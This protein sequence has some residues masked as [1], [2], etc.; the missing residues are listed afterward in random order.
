[1]IRVAWIELL[2]CMIIIAF[3]AAISLSVYKG[4]INNA[5]VAH[6]VCQALDS[7]AKTGIALHYALT[8]NWPSGMDEVDGLGFGSWGITDRH[9][10]LPMEVEKGA[11]HVRLMPPLSALTVSVR[12]AVATANPLGPVVWFAGEPLR[13]AGWDI[14]GIDRTTVSTEFIHPRMR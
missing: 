7:E 1:M 6:A 5:R 14:A 3:L 2:I 13:P 10:D 4:Y 9:G 12:P 8:G 11:M